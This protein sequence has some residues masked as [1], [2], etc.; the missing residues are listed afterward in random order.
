MADVLY[1]THPL[2]AW[3]PALEALGDE[4]AG[5]TVEAE[6]PVAAVDV[7]VDP[8]G[9][10]LAA[11]GRVLG[12]ALP[13][14]PN[15]WTPTGQGQLVWLGPAEWLVTDANA[16][17]HELEEDLS[18]VVSAYDGAVVDVSAQRTSLRLR[19][20]KARELLSF[21]CS[22]DLRPAKFPAGSCAQTA[23]G[24]AGVLLLALGE[25]DLRLFVRPSFAGYLAEW[26]LD[27]AEEFRAP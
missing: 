12:A 18:W 11:L 7:R 25:D 22:L 20:A 27:A 8:D 9:C 2:S 26:L 14:E 23:V 10:G 5:C 1:R 24:Q 16:L 21:G 15:T 4:I 17:P 3:Q 6:N 19:G 13:T